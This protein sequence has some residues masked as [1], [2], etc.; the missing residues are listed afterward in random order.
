[1]R[2]TQKT[3]L[4]FLVYASLAIVAFVITALLFL[5]VRF[6][7]HTVH[8]VWRCMEAPWFDKCGVVLLLTFAPLVITVALTLKAYLLARKY[9][10]LRGHQA[11]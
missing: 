7:A 10:S 8:M 9:K 2:E 1:M 4:L 5:G 6:P 3:G 11:K